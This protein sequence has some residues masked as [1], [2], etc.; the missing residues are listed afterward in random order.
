MGLAALLG[1]VPGVL[2]GSGAA[3]AQGF[4]NASQP[5]RVIV[6]NDRGGIV[7]RRV[8]EIEAIRARGQSVEIRGQICYS[9][10][11]MYLGLPQAC[12]LPDTRFGFHGPSH[13]GQQLSQR[14][15]D[16]WSRIIAAHYPAPLRQWYMEQGRNTR[17]G[18]YTISGAE[19]IRLGVRRC[20]TGADQGR[21]AGS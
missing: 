3:M 17:S 18:Y 4:S 12:V 2:S 14:D 8:A 16:Y 10:C 5:A 11:T 21:V 15:F 20:Q 6:H 1:V 9:S 19:L 13:F 7:S